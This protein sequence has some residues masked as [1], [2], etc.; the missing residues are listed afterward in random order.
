MKDWSI[1]LDEKFKEVDDYFAT[2]TDD[3]KA[4]FLS[5]EQRILSYQRQVDDRSRLD[6]KQQV[7]IDHI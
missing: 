6:I 1:N 4:R 3:P 5:A 7:I 2:I